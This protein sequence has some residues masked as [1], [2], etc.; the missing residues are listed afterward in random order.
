VKKT[1]GI[2][3]IL[4]TVQLAF[5]WTSG[6]YIKNDANKL[7]SLTSVPQYKE[8]VKVDANG[9][10]DINDEVDYVLYNELYVLDGYRQAEVRL[11]YSLDPPSAISPNL[12]DF[13]GTV[14]DI[15]GKRYMITAASGGIVTM[16]EPIE[17]RI[18]KQPEFDSAAGKSVVGDIKFEL[19]DPASDANKM[20]I[21]YVMKGDST[22][23]TVDMDNDY[24]SGQFPNRTEMS[25]FIKEITDE[26]NG[27]K[28]FLIDAKPRKTTFALVKNDELFDIRD[29]QTDIF[30]YEE[31]KINDDEFGTGSNKGTGKIK[32]LGRLYTIEKDGEA[33]V[34][35]SE[36]YRLQFNDKNKF[37]MIRYSFPITNETVKEQL[38][39]E[40]AKIS[41]EWRG[42]SI[43]SYANKILALE[44]YGP[45]Y[46]W[47][48]GNE[49]GDIRDEEDYILY[50][51]LYVLDGAQK[52]E[53]GLIY[54]LEPP[55][56][57]EFTKGPFGNLLGQT[58]DIKGKKYLVTHAEGNKI[59]IGEG[60]IN[61]ALKK[62]ET[63]DT[64]KIINLVDDIGMLRV[65]DPEKSSL[66]ELY[67]YK[68]ESLLGSFEL[69]RDKRD[70]SFY[71][72]KVTDLLNDYKIILSNNSIKYA[73]IALV[74]KDKLMTIMDETPDVF[75][76]DKVYVNN[77]EFPEAR[78]RVKFLSKIYTIEKDNE[79]PL[80]D[81][82]VYTLRY[83]KYGEF[84]IKKSRF[85]K[86]V[87]PVNE[88]NETVNETTPLPET[89]APPLETPPPI[90]AGTGGSLL[91]L[92]KDE[93]K[94][95]NKYMETSEIPGVLRGFASGRYIVHVDDET[96]GIVLE[97]GMIT[98]VR[99]GGLENPTIEVWTSRDYFD[100]IYSSDGALS[101]IVAGLNNGEI[102]KKDY[103]FGGKMKGRAGL[104]AM[105][106]SEVLRPT[107]ITLTEEE[108]SGDVKD[109]T[110]SVVEGT[111]AMNPATSNLRRTH[112]E[113]KSPEEKDIGG[114]EIKVKE[115]AGY[116][117]GKAPKGLSKW[118]SVE[119]ETS[120][121][122][123]VDIETE[124]DVEYALIFIKYSKEEVEKRGLSEDSLYIKWYDDNPESDTYG[125][126][127]TLTEG[128]PAWVH[129]IAYDKENEGVWVKT[130]H[131]SVYGL[132]GRVYGV[133]GS[134]YGVSGHVIGPPPEPLPEVK[135]ETTVPIEPIKEVEQPGLLKRIFLLTKAIILG[136]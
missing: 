47:V 126:W 6:T 31:V 68:G 15:K 103:G 125:Q 90:V 37:R 89:T 59:V 109:L 87:V 121:G 14:V 34:E 97:D 70:L 49:D 54:N 116:K 100:K 104:A 9:D 102:E 39:N 88:T 105:R 36:P 60:P 4:L 63:S 115:Y 108:A 7:Y 83:N 73:E 13:V 25:R 124:V 92:V 79:T 127:I 71:V 129:S 57:N 32:F 55:K 130:S 16:G 53:V 80:E 52:A 117:P 35:D 56:L 136:R 42:T 75:G 78:D 81:N 3:A 112:I 27:Y 40:T 58:L 77:D 98:G 44:D 107:K 38:E 72:S 23:G 111:Y 64:S 8:P 19:V 5:A 123:F 43:K 118:E 28:I 134:V 61:K 24:N 131:F 106:L 18:N 11:V 20:G 120:L 135:V 41:T 74:K 113:M 114:E 82:D 67:I 46:V 48:D 66:G 85:L 95:F 29:M 110:K 94:D 96:V 1:L 84:R 33:R 21:L 86:K 65:G 119:G 69:S 132:G 45:E 30:G 91:E 62:S 122:T 17:V 12:E 51:Q 26:L 50:N 99:D 10:G 93:Q 133:S 128:N 22:L 76:Y 2:I 101:L